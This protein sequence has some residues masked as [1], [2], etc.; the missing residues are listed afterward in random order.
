MKKI[1]KLLMVM[2]CFAMT[3]AIYGQTIT[4]TVN[5]EDGPLPGANI[6]VKG[7]K[8]GTTTDF[9]GKF[10]LKVTEGSGIIEVSFIGYANKDISYTIAAGETKDLGTI[11]LTS[12]NTLEEIVIVGT[13]IVDLIKDRQT[14]IAVSTILAAEIQEKSGNLEFPELMKSTPSVYATKQGGGFGDSRV[15]LRGFDQTNTAFLLNGQPINGME[16]GKMYWSNWSGVTDV[17]NAIQ[18]QRGLGSSK[19][20]ISSV[21]GTVNIVTKTTD[22]REGGFAKFVYGNDAYMKG[23]IGYSS[24]SG[25]DNNGLGVTILFSHWQ[26]DGYNDGTKGQGQSYFV[27]IGKKLGENHNINFLITGAPQWHDNNFSKQISVFLDKGRKFNNN[28]GYRNGEY[29]TERRNFYHKPVANF[30]WDWT[31]NDK[32]QLSTVLYGSWGRG[33][34]TGRFG[35]GLSSSDRYDADGQVAFDNLIDYNATVPNSIGGISGGYGIRASVNNHAWYGVV[36]NFNHVINDK[37]NFNIGFDGRM[38]KGTHF[39]NFVDFLGLQG[40]ERSSNYLGTYTIDETFEADPWSALFSPNNSNNQRYNWDYEEKINYIGGFAQ[41]EYKTEN[42]SGYIQGAVSS[43]SHQRWDYN[44][45]AD[46]A[47]VE[48]EKITNPGFNLKG[49]MNFKFDDK[50]NL[51]FNAGFYSRQP[52]HDNIYLNFRNDVNPLTENEE[53]GGLEVG[54]GYR[55]EKFAANVNLYYTTWGNRVITNSIREDFFLA[56]GVTLGQDGDDENYFGN[57]AGISEIHQGIEVDFTYRPFEKFELKGYSS[58]GE[59]NYS[60]DARQ[61]LYDEDLN[62]VNNLFG[63]GGTLNLDGLRIG[64]AA[65][66]SYGLG[67]RYNILDNLKVDADWNNYD[68]LYADFSP[69]RAGE[70]RLPSYDLVDF[71]LT[72]T[73]KL[74][75]EKTLKFRVNVNNVFDE[76]YIS[77]SDS[78]IAASST[79]S[80]NYRGVNKDNRVYFGFGRTFNASLQFKF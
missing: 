67:A 29:E 45:Y 74:G 75:D 12:D 56:D 23:T 39:R 10:S 21:G 26:G 31:I 9:D 44:N 17:A 16:D 41:F 78:N 34:G 22:K 47:D 66:F 13:G 71:G 2:M 20:A 55:G 61:T 62:V 15:N 73:H 64:D 68:G 3:S 76:V 70:V 80:E 18:I 49:G 38:Y 28:W 77:E 6:I 7:T 33:G 65:Q 27:S 1:T 25:E 46:E 32:S 50:N 72:Y 63:G 53:I 42:L 58:L 54:Y 4:G 24:G 19:L 57:Y 36:S 48:S 43:Q 14:P 59:W 30:N 60:G 52:F 79:A 40:F 37:W 69:N 8:N 11:V 5:A 51:Y 35:W